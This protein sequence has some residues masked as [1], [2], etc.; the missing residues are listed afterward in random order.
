MNLLGAGVSQGRGLGPLIRPLGGRC[1]C[2]PGQILG[3]LLNSRGENTF[4]RAC[5]RVCVQ[6]FSFV[7]RARPEDVLRLRP[8]FLS[9]L[10]VGFG[11]RHKSVVSTVPHRFLNLMGIGKNKRN[12]ILWPDKNLLICALHHYMHSRYEV[13][14]RFSAHPPSH[15]T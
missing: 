9:E 15:P 6:V 5:M 2:P 1:L 14:P 8:M 4:V 7:A 13:P 10:V 3:P 12:V 11:E